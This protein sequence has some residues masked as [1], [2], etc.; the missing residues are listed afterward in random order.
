MSTL[1]NVKQAFGP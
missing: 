1:T